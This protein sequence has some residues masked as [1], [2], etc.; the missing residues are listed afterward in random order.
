MMGTERARWPSGM[1]VKKARKPR[2]LRD[3]NEDLMVF[4]NRCR[5]TIDRNHRIWPSIEWAGYPD[6]GRCD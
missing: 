3:P 5:R 6:R 1:F 2:V 4:H